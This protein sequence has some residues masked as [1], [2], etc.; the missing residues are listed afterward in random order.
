MENLDTNELIEQYLNGTLPTAEKQAVEA[1]II[2][3][4]AFRDELE[5]HRQLHA[6]FEDPQK[7]KLRDLLGDILREPPPATPRQYG[8]WLKGLGLAGVVLLAV[9]L[10][11]RRLSPAPPTL[12]GPP[13]EK[14]VLPPTQPA[15]PM[16]N[17]NAPPKPLES[18]PER[19]IAMADPVAFIPN[20]GFEDR[21]GSQIRAAGGS[22][23]LQSP[24]TGANFTPQNGFVKIAFR[25]TAP[26]GADTTE[27]PLVLKI[28]ANKTPTGEALFRLLPTIGNRH[29]ATD[30]WTFSC[31]QPLRLRP[32]LYYFT[33]ERQADEDLIFTGKFTVGAR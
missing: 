24:T 32:G 10:G 22:V 11:L 12:P 15:T 2:T 23:N 5:L 18:T 16:E 8:N 3:D 28:Y 30:Q 25:G 17:E 20:R 29:T 6:E 1:R 33:L 9:W 14:S 19:P 4:A 7:L 13:E 26:V 27:Y 31:V 21:I